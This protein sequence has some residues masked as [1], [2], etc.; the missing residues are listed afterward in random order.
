MELTSRFVSRAG[1]ER[2]SYRVEIERFSYRVEIE[3]F[4]YRVEI[5]RF[6]YRVG[7]ERL[8][9]Q[10]ERRTALARLFRE[11]LRPDF[12]HNKFKPLDDLNPG[13]I[14]IRCS[15]NRGM[16]LRGKRF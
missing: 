2:F 14:S 3:R 6:S 12:F 5:E 15:I 10:R 4:S 13:F 11:V 1:T 7:I 16:I 9:Y 8:N